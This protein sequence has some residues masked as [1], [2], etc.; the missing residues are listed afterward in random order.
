VK[1][2][3]LSDVCMSMLEFTRNVKCDVTHQLTHQLTHA[4]LGVSAFPH[5]DVSYFRA[6]AADMFYWLGVWR[7]YPNV[8]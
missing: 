6:Y 2:V 5:C 3:D 8:W 7:V 4:D 1:S